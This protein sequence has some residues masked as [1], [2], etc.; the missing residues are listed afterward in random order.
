MK[1]P[2]TLISE[3]FTIQN[4]LNT[5]TYDSAWIEKGR[6]EEFDYAMAAGD[7]AHE[8]ARSLPFQ[9]W[10]GDS[11]DRQ[12]QVTEIVDAW[13]FVMSQYIIDFNGNVGIAA[14]DAFRMYEMAAPAQL[15]NTV[16]KQT[17]SFVAAMYV[18]NNWNFDP[19]NRPNFV[20]MFFLWCRKADVSLELLYARYLAKA[21]LNKFRV[22]N[23]YKQKL[24]DKIWEIGNE[25]G[26]DNF[27]LARWVDSKIAQGHTPT[28][29][30]IALWL[31]ETYCMHKTQKGA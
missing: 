31:Q 18:H 23:G 5:K 10:T 11:P 9:W 14:Q 6:T 7:E 21:T 1:K 4:G 15:Q 25:K 24:Y 29:N 17:K 20:R 3:M 28:E 2:E 27:F 26:E 16:K 13:H 12:N 19:K 8:F 22:E 30:D